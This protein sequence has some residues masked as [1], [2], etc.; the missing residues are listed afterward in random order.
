MA[1]GMIGRTYVSLFE[2][3][4]ISE[5]EIIFEELEEKLNSSILESHPLVYYNTLLEVLEDP[6]KSTTFP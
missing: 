4:I 2:E 3:R 1:G 5:E 6:F